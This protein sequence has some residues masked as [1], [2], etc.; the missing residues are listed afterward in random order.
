MWIRI[1]QLFGK[2]APRS[3]GL[4]LSGGG[5]RGLAHIGVLKVL[6]QEGIPIDYLAGTSAGGLIAA[7]YAT[8]LSAHDIEDEA[9]RLTDRR[10]LLAL[11][12]RRLPQRGL[13]AGDKLAEY[14]ARRLGATTFDQLRVPLA[15]V[16]VDLNRSEEVVLREG[17][18]L[19]AVRATIALPGLLAPVERGEQLLV[20]GGLLN[21]LP[22]DVVRQMG[23]DVVIAV[24]ISTDEKTVAS[25]AAELHQYRFVP[26]NLIEIME[27]LWRSLQVLTRASQ[28]R[29]LAEAPPDLLIRPVLPVG[30]TVL[31]GLSRAAE[32]IAAGERA[33]REALP[34]LGE[35]LR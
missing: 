25:F 29:I 24:D 6:E 21:N 23:A 33:T 5:A 10:Q 2:G 15:V 27:V 13:L 12:D 20:D 1:K 4:A 35:L 18:V 9:L 16:A 11:I 30:V 14:L 17:A 26:E 19:E 32:T 3:V 22:T 31:T 7:A 28:R 34:A 8:G